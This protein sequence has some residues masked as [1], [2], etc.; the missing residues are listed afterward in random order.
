MVWEREPEAVILESATLPTVEPGRYDDP[1]IMAAFL[2]A[3]RWGA[4]TSADA[5]SMQAPFRS[6]VRIEDYQLDPVVRAL[7]SPRANLLIADDVGLGKTIETG[8]VAQEMILRQRARRIII[9]VPADLTTKWKREMAEKFGLDF[10][11]VDTQS[12]KELRRSHGPHANPWA[13]W[14][15]TIVSLPWLRGERGTRALDDFLPANAGFPRVF[16]LLI[17]DEAHH[18]APSG[19]GRYAIDSQ[20]TRTMR[21]LAPHCENRLFLTA[22]PHN[23]YS[24][25]FAALL[26]LLDPQRFARGT[27]PDKAALAEVMIRRTK[28]DPIFIS[29][30]GT[31]RFPERHVR[32][33]EFTFGD[34][35]IEAQRLLAVYTGARTGSGGHVVGRAHDMVTMLLKKRLFSSP[36]AFSS[37]LRVHADTSRDANRQQWTETP[38]WLEE[39]AAAIEDDYALDAERDAAEEDL[40]GKAAAVTGPASHDEKR[41]LDDLLIWAEQHGQAP[42]A[43]ADALLTW[44]R[45]TLLDANGKWTDE[46]VV[47][48]TE[49]RT[50]QRWLKELLDADGLGGAH[51]SL[52]YGGQDD[53]E[54]QRVKDAFQAAPDRDPVR[55]L[56]ATDSASEGI[57]LQKHCHR[58]VSYDIPFNPQRLEQRVGRVDRYGQKHDVE[59]R[60]FASMGWHD[61]T[62]GSFEADLEFLSRVATKIATIREDLGKVNRLIASA[63]E[64]R[65]TGHGDAEMLLDTATAT[66]SRD[67]L[68]F[69]LQTRERVQAA[70]AELNASMENLRVAPANVERVVATALDLA[71]Q[72]PLIASSVQGCWTVGDRTGMWIRATENLPDPLDPS[73]IRPV[74]FDPEVA[75]EFDEDVVLAH[76]G[77]PLVAHATR[78]LRAKVWAPTGIDGL[79]RVA[80]CVI[81]DEVTDGKPAVA[82]FS[83]LVIAGGDGYRLHEE[84]FASGGTLDDVGRWTRLGVQRLENV[85]NQ[86]LDAAA[87]RDTRRADEIAG[88]WERLSDLLRSAYEAR[89]GERYESLIRDLAKKKDTD[90]KRIREVLT[91]LQSTIE[92]ALRGPGVE[93]LELFDDAERDQYV[94]DKGAWERR[95]AEIPVEIERETAAIEAR[96]ADLTRHVFPAAIVIA[97]PA[98]IA[99]GVA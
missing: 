11:I 57:D 1:Q 19:T 23:G 69:E 94:A 74:T 71:G 50:T 16:D 73:I 17:V 22:T 8:L 54:R 25:S 42:D 78:L 6:G 21:R 68:A 76:L 38:A 87:P 61:A 97:L 60:H 89:A 37:T 80:V 5:G 43:K 47:I 92:A 7:R 82:A 32:P 3:V 28:D 79:R 31:R 58:M 40:L 63:V 35:E 29:E 36:A 33:I 46:R 14:P 99:G 20:Q 84:V 88:D 34:A 86:A 27:A 66:P 53:K 30:D 77:H 18:L 64:A 96:Y 75:A 9:V 72:P 44:L 98:S 59:I 67:L 91:Q 85:L 4:V 62:P 26:E 70:R 24:N 55:I 93:Q 10:H 49:Y 56:L 41:L 39:A 2:D 81:P 65:M 13:V 12:I 95:L 51:L 15:R 83:R 90:T 48:F 45:K 52:I